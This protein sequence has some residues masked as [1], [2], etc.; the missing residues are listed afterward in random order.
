MV[1][2]QESKETHTDNDYVSPFLHGWLRITA[3]YA[4]VT[5]VQTKAQLELQSAYSIEHSLV[6]LSG[7]DVSNSH[8]TPW[9]C[10]GQLSYTTTRYKILDVPRCYITM[11]FFGTFKRRKFIIIALVSYLASSRSFIG[12]LRQENQ[13]AE[14]TKF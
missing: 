13:S 5:Q 1:H 12:F 9:A 3:T 10:R 4:D 6:G 14:T 11:F 7:H 8:L 2:K